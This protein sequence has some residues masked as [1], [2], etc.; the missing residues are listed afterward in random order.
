MNIIRVEGKLTQLFHSDRRKL[1]TKSPNR[2]NKQSGTNTSVHVAT[3]TGYEYPQH[4][5]RNLNNETACNK[6]VYDSSERKILWKSGKNN[7]SYG[8]KPFINYKSSLS[9]SESKKTSC[10]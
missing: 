2:R 7:K 3:M 8:P 4:P 5:V 9:D 10:T 1:P 6:T